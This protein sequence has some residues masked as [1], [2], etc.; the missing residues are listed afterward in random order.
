MENNDFNKNV[1]K[2]MKWSKIC[3]ITTM[4]ISLFGIG[5]LLLN[6]L[7]EFTDL[8]AKVPDLYSKIFALIMLVI[9][10]ALVTFEIFCYVKARKY[11]KLIEKSE[12]DKNEDANEQSGSDT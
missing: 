5:A 6:I 2:F 8:E 1:D 11:K 7:K 3:I 12:N 10:L 9:F 4:I